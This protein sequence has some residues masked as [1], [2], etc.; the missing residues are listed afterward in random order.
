MVG[1]VDARA[2]GENVGHLTIEELRAVDDGLE[3]VL[4]LA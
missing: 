4:D 1:P 2:L 3:L